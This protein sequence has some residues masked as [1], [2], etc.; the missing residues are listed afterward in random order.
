MEMDE[1]GRN[2]DKVRAGSVAFPYV[3][4]GFWGGF[5]LGILVGGVFVAALMTAMFV[6]ATRAW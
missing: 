5:W 4:P 2:D 3:R 6:V 1:A